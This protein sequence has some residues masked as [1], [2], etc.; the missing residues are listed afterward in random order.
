MLIEF[1]MQYSKSN[2]TFLINQNMQFYQI[3]YITAEV[4]YGLINI[5][6]KQILF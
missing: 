2:K 1:I 5:R 3:T 6:N 4:S